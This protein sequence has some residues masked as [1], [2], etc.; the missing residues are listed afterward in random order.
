MR[1]VHLCCIWD[2]YDYLVTLF[3]NY[4]VLKKK[5]KELL[6]LN[7]ILFK[8]IIYTVS[9]RRQDLKKKRR[10]D[11]L[12]EITKT[13]HNDFLKIVFYKKTLKCVQLFSYFEKTLQ[14]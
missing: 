12:L 11:L 8:N 6:G 9:K 14:V 4:W 7:A 5:K 1:M 10:Q 2:L 3:K 13:Y